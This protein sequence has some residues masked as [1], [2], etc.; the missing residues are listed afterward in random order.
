MSEI[1][2]VDQSGDGGPVFRQ[3]LI[4]TLDQQLAQTVGAGQACLTPIQQAIGSEATSPLSVQAIPF[5]ERQTWLARQCWEEWL[6]P[7][8]KRLGQPASTRS[9]QLTGVRHWEAV[10]ADQ[11]RPEPAVAVIG[12]DD[13]EL[14]ATRLQEP[15]GEGGRGLG[16]HAAR[17]V[18][19]IIRHLIREAHE[20]GLRS[21]VATVEVGSP[22]PKGRPGLVSIGEVEAMIRTAWRIAQWP[23]WGE[24]P[25]G[26]FWE[27]SLLLFWIYGARTQ[28]FVRFKDATHDG[29]LWSNISFDATCPDPSARGDDGHTLRY[30][31]GWLDYQPKKT[32]RSK[33]ER[34]TLP[35]HPAV[36]ERL[37][38]F[39]GLDERVFPTTCT[40]SHLDWSGWRSA[41]RAIREAAEVPDDVTI[42]GSGAANRSI[43]KACS[44]NWDDLHDGLGM[45]VLGHG[46]RGVH[47]SHYKSCLRRIVSGI[48]RL[49]LPAL[50]EGGRP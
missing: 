3:R 2:S 6:V 22:P 26:L 43:R 40:K 39:Q 32:A 37:K 35:L 19:S 11:E 33:G 34:I 16:F 31:H 49:R 12:R 4:V 1:I 25:P 36:A 47:N 21:G 46:R 48:E 13:L 30:P 50:E 14:V 41:F 5:D 28:D 7:R 27:T 23:R 42:S 10:W 20:R 8:S 44:N 17:K 38:R 24:L 9:E 15:K 18:L 29:L 45:W